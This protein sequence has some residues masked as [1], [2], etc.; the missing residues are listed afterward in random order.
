MPDPWTPVPNW[1]IEAMPDMSKATFCVAMAIARKTTGYHKE[2]D[3]I[4]ISQFMAITGMARPT[5]VSAI[6][7]GAGRWFERRKKGH[8]FEYRTVQK[9]NQNGKEIELLADG[10][11]SEIEPLTVQKLNQ[12][13][14]E[15][16]H[17]KEENIKKTTTTVAA[18]VSDDKSLRDTNP[19]FAK[20][21]TIYEQNIG[22]LTP[23]LAEELAD[24]VERYGIERFDAAMRLA[25]SANVR[26]L[27][28]IVGC[29]KKWESGEIEYHVNGT[30]PTT[31]TGEVNFSWDEVGA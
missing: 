2:W 20:A 26:K 17:T 29:L 23:M 27:K 6:E 18:A 25:V 16:E 13:G 1:L 19:Q 12:N 24:V 31:Q 30:G 3:T 7:A 8:S 4:S 14:K 9:L 21:C 11:S 5:V 28:Y 22:M 10:N 15:I